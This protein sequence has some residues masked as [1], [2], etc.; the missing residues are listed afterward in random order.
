MVVGDIIVSQVES[1]FLWRFATVHILHFTDRVMM[2]RFIILA[3]RL[4]WT[5]NRETGNETDWKH[6]QL[7]MLLLG[8]IH[9]QLM[10]LRS[11]LDMV[12][13]DNT[14]SL[15]ISVVSKDRSLLYSLYI[16]LPQNNVVSI[17]IT[18]EYIYLQNQLDYSSLID[19]N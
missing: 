11:I 6:N 19:Y 12:L 4:I 13:N 7:N 3:S 2:V 18:T 15:M 10:E 14:H 1:N 17:F 9:I 8:T 5:Q 16:K